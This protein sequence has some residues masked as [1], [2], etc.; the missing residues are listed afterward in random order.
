MLIYELIKMAPNEMIME[1]RDFLTENVYTCFFTNY[2]LEHNGKKLGDFDDISELDL[3]TDNKIYM[4]PQLY[5]E[6]NARNH[7][8][9][10][11]DLLTKPKQLHQ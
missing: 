9:K 3:T 5:T 11:N 4:R 2:F 6:K 10:I 8:M 1:T 7:I